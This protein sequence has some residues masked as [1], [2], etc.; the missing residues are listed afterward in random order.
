MASGRGYEDGSNEG[1]ITHDEKV[2]KA[3][4]ILGM[5]EGSTALISADDQLLAKLGYRAELKREFSYLT[6]FGQSFGAMGIAPAIAE[7]I[8]FSLGSG[9]SV[10]MVWTY[11]A[12]CL[13]LIP[14]A[15]SLGELGSAMPTS[16]GIYYWVARLTPPRQRAF[17]CWLAGYMN[18]L[19]YISIYA[20][21]IYA[22]TLLLG[23][24]IA[25]GRDETCFT[26]KYHNY[27]MF[28]A[29]TLLTFGM[30]CVSSAT[31]SK[32]NI[33]YIFVQ[34]AILLSVIVTLAAKTPSEYKNS[35]HFVF[36]DFENTGFWP[37]DGWAFMM[38]FLT[39]VWVVSGFESSATIAEEASNAAKAVPF[40]M[41][42]SL[43]VATITGWAVIITIAFCM[44]TGIIDIVETPLGQPFAQIAFNNLGKNGAIALLVFLWFSS[45]CNCSI[46]MVAA[47]R[48]TFA[49]SR[50]HG[51]P[52]SGFLRQ[53]SANKTPA[54]AVGF[55]AVCTLIEGLLMFVNTIAINSIFNLAIMGL[56]FAY[57][58]PLVSRL[59]FGHFTPGVFYMG[60]IISIISAIYSI[61]WMTFIF[62]LLLF[63]IYPS[64]NV[65]EMNY[66]VA[67]LG[68]VLAFCV[69]Y[70]YFPK[71]GGKTFFT[72]PVR[73]I[74]DI[75]DESPEARA[76]V[77]QQIAKDREVAMSGTNENIGS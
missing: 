29:M 6:V 72:G 2:N 33:F 51:L 16:G 25:I 56:Y 19:G 41:I 12:G 28:A 64:P 55:V 34:L 10:G 49:F 40:A 14:V 65:Q 13:L 15:A 36:T 5:E 31:L 75:L 47:S 67:V 57:C 42:S 11:L 43:V 74:D 20:S 3:H 27:G 53:L 50:D 46:L 71:Y 30:T 52:F 59:C 58:M 48:E 32:L 24:T 22:A 4:A 68:F 63:P 76:A 54:R 69:V 1:S 73:T 21:T 70:Y 37:N 44:G 77:E 8:V 17:V 39:P 35:A 61:A 66:A 62:I 26:S 60:D 45:V 38:S 7:S 23:A 9:G 18:V